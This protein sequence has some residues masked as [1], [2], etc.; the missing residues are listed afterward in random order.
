M[1]KCQA[2]KDQSQKCYQ[3]DPV[4][5]GVVLVFFLTTLGQEEILS[6]LELL[7]PKSSP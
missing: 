6:P 1:F 3:E 7:S 5:L 2:L 4:N